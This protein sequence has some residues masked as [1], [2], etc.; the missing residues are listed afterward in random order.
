[1]HTAVSLIREQAAR[2]GEVESKIGGLEALIVELK[3]SG[4]EADLRIDAIMQAEADRLRVLQGRRAALAE[5]REDNDDLVLP[6]G[7]EEIE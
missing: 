5:L 1:M 4:S 6:N 7:A 3:K 2:L